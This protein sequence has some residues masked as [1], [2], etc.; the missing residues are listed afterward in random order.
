MAKRELSSWLLQFN[1]LSK[2]L[3]SLWNSQI[4]M[5]SRMGWVVCFTDKTVE[6]ELSVGKEKEFPA[7]V[8]KRIKMF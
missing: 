5:K 3:V 7:A 2:N 4:L 6:L 8:S 1:F